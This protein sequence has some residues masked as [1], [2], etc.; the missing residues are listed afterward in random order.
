MQ[1]KFKKSN[2]IVSVKRMVQIAMLFYLSTKQKTND[3]LNMKHKQ[4]ISVQTTVS[5]KVQRAII[6][7]RHLYQKT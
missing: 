2:N 1:T 7:V 3:K 4:K 6:V 5:I